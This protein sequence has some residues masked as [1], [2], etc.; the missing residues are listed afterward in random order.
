V[1]PIVPAEAALR[2]VFNELCFNLESFNPAFAACLLQ[3][4]RQDKAGQAWMPLPARHTMGSFLHSSLQ[5]RRAGRLG[6]HGQLSL[7][8]HTGDFL[9][10]S[11]QGEGDVTSSSGSGRVG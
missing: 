4:R 2:P 8:V 1:F 11:R 3:V 6:V 10:S 9:H 7:Q 5:N